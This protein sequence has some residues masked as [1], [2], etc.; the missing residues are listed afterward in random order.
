MAEAETLLPLIAV[1]LPL[2]D[3]VADILSP[4]LVLEFDCDDGNAVDRQHHIHAVAV[5][6]RVM[7]LADALAGVR[8][9]FLDQFAVEG[10]FRPEIADAEIDAVILEA[11]AENMDESA[12]RHHVLKAFEKA[13]FRIAVGL[14]DE[15]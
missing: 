14:F 8:L 12:F 1:G 4:Q 2:D 9:I 6:R 15:S 10:G 7:P 3:T 5:L 11:V 13:L